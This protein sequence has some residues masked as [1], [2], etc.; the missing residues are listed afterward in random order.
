MR[1][2]LVVL[3]VALGASGCTTVPAGYRGVKVYYLGTGQGVDTVELGIGRYPYWPLTQ[4]IYKFPVFQ[5][6]VVWSKAAGDGISF[7]TGEGVIVGADLG[8]S[9]AIEPTK[10]A[11]LFQKYRRGIEE[12]TENFLRH[13]VVD[14]CN[15]VAAEMSVEAVYGQ[16]KV[17]LLKR[18]NELVAEEVRPYGINIQRIHAIGEFRLPPQV[19]AAINTKIEATQRAQQRENELRETQAEA[20]KR[21]AAAK[22]EADA[23]RLRAE[24]DAAISRVRAEADAA[25]SRARA[26]AEAHNIR[27]R[28]QALSPRVLKYEA[29]QRWNG[30]LPRIVGAG[31]S[32]PFISV[33]ELE[34]EEKASPALVPPRR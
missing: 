8:M 3:V 9:Y 14:A 16:G 6:N 20:A 1:A 33:D 7:Q 11:V 34:A 28:E 21:V 12:I 17:Q 15:M 24:A 10:V 27:Q 31:A 25:N 22:G 2:W 29:I 4:A 26:E 19:V 18:V 5:Q 30:Q 23:A 13:I 32:V